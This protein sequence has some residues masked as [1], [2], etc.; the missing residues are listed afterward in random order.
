L[1]RKDLKTLIN[2]TDFITWLSCHDFRKEA[3][4]TS[5]VSVYKNIKRLEKKFIAYHIRDVRIFRL[6]LLVAELHKKEYIKKIIDYI[7]NGKARSGFDFLPAYNFISS[8]SIL[9]TGK[10]LVTYYI[11]SDFISDIL[12]EIMFASVYDDARIGSAIPVH[13]CC[14]LG[15]VSCAMNIYNSVLDP[16]KIERSHLLDFIITSVLDNNPYSRLR[17]ISNITKIAEARFLEY[18][19]SSKRYDKIQIHEPNRLRYKFI[20][21]RYQV[22]SAN[23][24]V[25]RVMVHINQYLDNVRV[26]FFAPRSCAKKVYGIIAGYLGSP[27]IILTYKEVIAGATLPSSAMVRI[28]EELSGC[29]DVRMDIPI[30]GWIYPLPFEY[31]DPF[32]DKSIK[33]PVDVYRI[34][35]KMGLLERHIR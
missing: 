25:G 14:K 9:M 16:P 3:P 13:N 28:G 35:R 33:E 21:K 1:N 15:D 6:V 27:R 4:G 12:T 32:Q 19:K 24:I 18:L 23:K 20:L 5:R 2:L 29:K 10:A 26:V 30:K 22:L 11:P 34:F 17:D 8:V 7:D 31:Y